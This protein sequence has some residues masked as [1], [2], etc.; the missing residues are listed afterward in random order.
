M[1]TLPDF[2]R[3][4]MTDDRWSEMSQYKIMSQNLDLKVYFSD[5]HSPW[6]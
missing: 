4:S 2:L 5:P 3:L 6:Q 1:K